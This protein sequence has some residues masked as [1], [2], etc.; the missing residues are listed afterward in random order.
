M[1]SICVWLLVSIFIIN[2]LRVS[3]ES[4]ESSESS[5]TI[6]RTIPMLLRH[7]AARAPLVSPNGA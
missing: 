3:F 7:A 5:A 2:F 4:F 6:T 1:Y